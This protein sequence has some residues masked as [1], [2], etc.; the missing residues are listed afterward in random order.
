MQGCRPPPGPSGHDCSRQTRTACRGLPRRHDLRGL[1]FK[2]ARKLAR[3]KTGAATHVNLAV[4]NG[5]GVRTSGSRHRCHLLP[6]VGRRVVHIHATHGCLVAFVVVDNAAQHVDLTV[7]HSCGVSAASHGRA[8][9]PS[10]RTRDGI[11]SFNCVAKV[12]V[13]VVTTDCIDLARYRH[14]R[15]AKARSRHARQRLPA[16]GLRVVHHRFSKRRVILNPPA[17]DI[18]LAS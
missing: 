17:H 1:S 12:P 16:I 4:Q 7:D 10:P 9:C 11:V 3:C 15:Q 18:E 5:R 13:N 6:A 8:R 2:S 14:G